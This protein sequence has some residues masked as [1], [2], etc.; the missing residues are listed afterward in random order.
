MQGEYKRLI[1][2]VN[3]LKTAILIFMNK[4]VFLLILMIESQK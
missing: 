1:I 2:N 3:D 4:F